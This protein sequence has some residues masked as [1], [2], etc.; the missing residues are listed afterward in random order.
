MVLGKQ[1]VFLN[2]LGKAKHLDPVHA[3]SLQEMGKM[4]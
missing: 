3:E 2:V 1:S 4:G